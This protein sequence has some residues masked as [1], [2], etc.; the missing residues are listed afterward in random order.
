MKPLDAH[1]GPRARRPSGPERGLWKGHPGGSGRRAERQEARGLGIPPGLRHATFSAAVVAA[2]L[3]LASSPAVQAQ[4]LPTGGVDHD[5]DDGYVRVDSSGNAGGLTW[6]WGYQNQSQVP[7]DGF[8]HFHVTRYECQPPALARKVVVTDRY[9]L[10]V[11]GALVI[12]PP[13][14]Y[15]GSREGPGPMI[16]DLPIREVTSTPGPRLRVARAPEGLRVAWDAAAV[17]FQLQTA[18]C[19]DGVG[20]WLPAAVIP[21]RVNDEWMVTLPWAAGQ[22]FCRLVSTNCPPVE[23]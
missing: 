20:C 13:P 15:A 10:Y 22:A 6:F 16:S 5:Y 2:L 1:A 17:D 14:P 12:P 19:P 11:G 7:D 3:A 8:I 4:G 23:P 21:S 18:T 9:S